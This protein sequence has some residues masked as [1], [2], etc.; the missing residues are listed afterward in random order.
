KKIY[1]F[2]EVSSTMDVAMQL[3]LKGA[4]EGT[5]VLSELQTKGRGR[6]GR[7]WFSPRYKGIYFSL[8]L[9][10]AISPNQAAVLTLLSAV[11]ICQAIRQIT[12]VEA[13]IKWPNDILIQQK[14]V[15]G[16][17]TEIQAEMDEI[18]CVIVGVGINVNN[19]KKSLISQA[20]SLKEHIGGVVNRVELLQAIFNALEKNY[21]HFQEKG[22][23]FIIQQWREYSV[24][25]GRRVK[26]YSHRE[27]VEGEAIDIDA[28][29]A[30]LLRNDAGLT[31]KILS[32]DVVHCR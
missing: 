6:L 11:S 21:L 2:D 5:V 1:Y 24:T 26:I 27:H 3:A 15:A 8:I 20:T 28:D 13:Q 7:N 25:L 30:L 19:E 23:R 18:H 29:G 22:S 12:G 17:L 14:K 32:G 10:P 31:Q 9:K 16:I 4:V